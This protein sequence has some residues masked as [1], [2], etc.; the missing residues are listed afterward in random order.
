M[1]DTWLNS[2][3]IGQRTRDSSVSDVRG[4]LNTG[5]LCLV[6][7]TADLL[8]VPLTSAMVPYR[9]LNAREP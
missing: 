8:W 4:V 9:A 2:P 6:I 3:Q 5:F 7:F 1:F